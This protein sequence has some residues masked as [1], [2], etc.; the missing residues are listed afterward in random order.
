MM[1]NRKARI[2][3]ALWIGWTSLMDWL[4]NACLMISIL[5]ST[6]HTVVKKCLHNFPHQRLPQ[7]WRVLAC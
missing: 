4:E 3:Q 5:S 1:T 2:L 7:K 6:I